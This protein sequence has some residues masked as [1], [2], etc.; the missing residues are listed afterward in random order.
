[1]QPVL[2]TK[3]PFLQSIVLLLQPVKDALKPTILLKQTNAARSAAF[4]HHVTFLAHNGSCPA[5]SYLLSSCIHPAHQVAYHAHYAVTCTRQ[6][7]FTSCSLAYVAYHDRHAHI[8]LVLHPISPAAYILLVLQPTSCL[9]CSLYP[10]RPISRPPS[11]S[12]FRIYYLSHNR[13][14]ET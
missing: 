2:A 13:K 14:R 1:M 4:A 12:S 10:A 3:Q 5:H 7:T 11:W 6:T 9:S 8:L